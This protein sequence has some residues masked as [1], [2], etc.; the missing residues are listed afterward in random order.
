[1]K[2]LF[3]ESEHVCDASPLPPSG[4][5]FSNDRRFRYNLWRSWAPGDSI[6][7]LML[8][9]SIADEITMDRTVTRCFNFSKSFGFGTMCITNVFPLVSPYPIDLLT[10]LDR[11][12]EGRRNL[13]HLAANLR[14]SSA[15]VIAFGT[16]PMRRE[17]RYALG[18]IG[19]VVL[20]SGIVPQ[21]LA[22]NADGSGKHPLYVAGS[23]SLIPFVWPTKR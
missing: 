8:N 7:F 2:S 3:N 22:I 16:W 20:Q 6:T 15:L 12:G 9:P 1:M 18:P 17:L 23:T 11:D 10:S 19:D 5:C 21:A 13:E 4:A 14:A